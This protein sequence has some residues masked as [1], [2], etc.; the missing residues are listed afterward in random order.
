M[1]SKKNFSSVCTEKTLEKAEDRATDK[2]LVEHILHVLTVHC[3]EF[4]FVERES[5]LV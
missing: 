3:D 5:F 4:S 1:Q 2:N